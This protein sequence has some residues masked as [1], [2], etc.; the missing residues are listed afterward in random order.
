MA[1]PQLKIFS[2]TVSS[3]TELREGFF[4]LRTAANNNIIGGTEIAHWQ[5]N[6]W[7]LVLGT[8]IVHQKFGPQVRARYIWDQKSSP[9][10]SEKDA[11]ALLE[12]LKNIPDIGPKMSE[13]ILI[14]YGGETKEVIEKDPYR[15]ITE[16]RVPR[17]QLKQIDQLAH[18]GGIGRR[19]AR[20]IEAVIMHNLKS[21][22]YG[23]GMPKYLDELEMYV[24]D[25]G[26]N[27]IAVNYQQLV[28]VTADKLSTEEDPISFEEV[29]KV[30]TGLAS[31]PRNEI[32]KRPQ[33]RILFDKAN[34]PLAVYLWN[35]YQAENAI[36]FHIRR[37]MQKGITASCPEI[38][39]NVQLT[40]E[41]REAVTMGLTHPISVI[42]GGPG[43][44]KTTIIEALTHT[45]QAAGK[46][47]KLCAPTG[48]AARRMRQTTERPAETVHRILVY[49]PHKGGFTHGFENPLQT[50]YV[51]CDETSMVDAPLM[52]TLLAAVPDNASVIFVGDA[53]Q[54]QP[55]G[56]GAPFIE[57]MRSGLIPSTKLT[58]VFRQELSDSLIIKGSQSVIN[59][60]EP[61]SGTDVTNHDLF[62]FRYRNEDSAVKTVMDL[63]LRRIPE[64]FGI[65]TDQIQILS[66]LR[67]EE[68][69]GGRIN[70]LS[71]TALNRHIQKALHGS[72]QAPGHRFCVGDRVVQVKNDYTLDVM[73]GQIGYV[74]NILPHKKDF[75]YVVEFDEGEQVKT[76]TYDPETSQKLELA[77][78]LSI[79][80]AQGTQSMATIVIAHSVPNFY[81]RNML[82]T[83]MTRGKRLVALVSPA[84]KSS[85][86]AILA[87]SE[88]RRKSYLRQ[89][90]KA[91]VAEKPGLV[92][93]D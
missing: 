26:G 40:S 24:G 23:R 43:V 32:D 13:K 5:R 28:G 75:S 44:G 58:K 46:T 93:L 82:Y 72:V 42:T 91:K 74:V 67:Q 81:S 2:D 53:D 37:I 88:R 1:E 47:V 17:I 30:L 22:S 34:N 18:A 92:E 45:F 64:K 39:T 76:V 79:H 61:E 7:I 60:E 78:A 83:A 57:I 10:K 6:E 4:R 89:M 14:A 11:H 8:E 65:P 12:Y 9:F 33:I 3:V 49:D 86:R 71:T 48:I 52:A 66:P 85:F 36:S 20:R 19:D 25:D 90:I 87:T 70:P 59:K 35:L 68:S 77:Y 69:K 62:H 29:E 73:N 27:H 84:D 38:Q 55:V 21:A 41:Q 15:I 31:R 63:A 56:P 16:G 80:K 51:I 50:D 54:L